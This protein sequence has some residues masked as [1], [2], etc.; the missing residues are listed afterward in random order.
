MT[1]PLFHWSLEIGFVVTQI[2]PRP[3]LTKG[4]WEDLVEAAKTV[5]G[6][7]IGKIHGPVRELSG[8][9]T[10]EQKYGDTHFCPLSLDGRGGG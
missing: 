8:L 10:A 2:P 1:K 7:L 3:P 9:S 5:I 4:G 6:D